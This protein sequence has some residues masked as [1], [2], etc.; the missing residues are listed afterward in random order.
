MTK[1]KVETELDKAGKQFDEFDQQI[2]DLTQDRMNE[3]PKLELEPQT[4]LSQRD[5]D[6]SKETYLKPKKAIGS[7]EKFDEKWRKRYEFDKEYVQ[8]IA[9]NKEIIGES[10]DLWTKPYPGCPAEEWIVPTNKPVWAPR[11]VAER[12]KGCVYHRL[13]MQDRPI[14]ADYAG[15]YTGQMVVDSTI[16]RLD[17]YPVNTR[18]SI[19]MGANN[20]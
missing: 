5:I 10:I 8:F 15:S 3:A 6:K 13:T 17:A 1:A 4:Q 9:E 7:R 18:R 2:K 11:Y 20:F 19:F 14:G 12:I 16:N